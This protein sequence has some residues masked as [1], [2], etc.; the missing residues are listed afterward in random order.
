M[1]HELFS[2]SG[3]RHPSQM[4]TITW[5]RNTIDKKIIFQLEEFCLVN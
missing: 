2:E 4:M 1:T 5:A 3:R